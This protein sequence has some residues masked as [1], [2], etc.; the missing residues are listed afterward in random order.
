MGVGLWKLRRLVYR[1]LGTLGCDCWSIQRYNRWTTLDVT[2][3]DAGV[4][5][6]DLLTILNGTT[7]KNYTEPNSITRDRTPS[8]SFDW[9]TPVGDALVNHLEK[10][11]T[12]TI[13][14]SLAKAVLHPHSITSFQFLATW[15]EHQWQCK[16]FQIQGEFIQEGAGFPECPLSPL[17]M[18]YDKRMI[19]QLVVFPNNMDNSSPRRKPEYTILLHHAAALRQPRIHTKE[20]KNICAMYLRSICVSTLGLTNF[21]RQSLCL[22]LGSLS[23]YH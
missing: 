5:Y 10:E 23:Y 9:N 21:V 16:S 19:L 17:R 14:E 1:G 7:V 22:H 12:K 13:R 20:N 8:R 4:A 6:Y 18:H 11:S 2:L 15:P 3:W